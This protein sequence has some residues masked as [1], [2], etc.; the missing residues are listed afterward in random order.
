MRQEQDL[1]GGERDK[2]KKAKSLIKSRCNKEYTGFEIKCK[3]LV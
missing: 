1:E 2:K 3:K